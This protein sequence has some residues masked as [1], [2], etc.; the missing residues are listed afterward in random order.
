MIY[1]MK[2][3]LF[4]AEEKQSTKE[5]TLKSESQHSSENDLH[6]HK[7][8]TNQNY[9]IISI[10][11]LGVI[12][13]GTI[14][15][16]LITNFSYTVGAFRSVFSVLS[17]F[18][19]AF[20]IAFILNPIVHMVDVK[21]LQKVF[22]IKSK[23][24][25]KFLAILLSYLIVIGFITVCLVYIIPQLL[26]T[27]S[28]L[29]GSVSDMTDKAVSWINSLQDKFSYI[30]FSKVE[31]KLTGLI[32]EIIS[33]GTDLLTSLFPTL[34]NISVSI[35]K[36]IINL[37]LSI[38]ISCYM[39]SDKKSL[40]KNLKRIIYSILPVKKANVLFDNVK[41]CNSIFT[42]FIVGKTIDSLIIGILCFILM[43]I[44]HL[45]Y[46]LLLSVIVGV[47]NMIPYFGPFI[48]AIP[49]VL[50]FLVI[51]PVKSIIFAFMILVLQQFDGLYL[52]PKILGES[53]GLKPLWVIFGITVGGACW[54]VLGMF[55]GVPITAVIAYLLD[56]LISNR[57]KKKN[58][59]IPDEE[60]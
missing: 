27:L 1:I 54:G 9:F 15:V 41:E 25:R 10:Y 38:V 16:N 2:E 31:E 37:L 56:K 8:R 59:T 3:V 43:S 49:G 51:D 47:T 18:I 57:L 6:S 23:K 36:V 11:V 28:E 17:P 52:G 44:L 13:I 58:I 48:G 53:T 55:L 4:L 21:L 19:T 34:I 50:I 29:N 39:L 24:V 46:A 60:D 12:A 42:G 32:P 35:I 40:Q 22:K 14:I 30:D 20:F 7:F 5:S 33:T 45:D 26:S